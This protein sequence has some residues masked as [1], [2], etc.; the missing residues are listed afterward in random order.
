MTGRTHDKPKKSA[1][2]LKTVQAKSSKRKRKA[3][4]ADRVTESVS[5]KNQNKKPSQI[6]GSVIDDI[7]G[8]LPRCENQQQRPHQQQQ[9]PG[10]PG[11]ATSGEGHKKGGARKKVIAAESMRSRLDGNKDDLFGTETQ[12]SRRYDAEG[13]PIFSVEELDIGKGKDTADCPFDCD[14]CF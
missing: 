9:V 14:C 13:L 2:S 1:A 7:F 11:L 3:A 6:T 10:R 12:G 5:N 4:D 8:S